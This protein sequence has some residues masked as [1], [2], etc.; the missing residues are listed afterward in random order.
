MLADLRYAIRTLIKSPGYA[1]VAV[2]TLA[3]GIGGIVAMFSAFYGV[4]LAPLPYPQASDIVVPVSTN[5]ARGISDGSVPYADYEDWGRERDVF[6]A[7]ALWL[8]VSVDVSAGS[9]PERLD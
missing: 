3:I 2:A 9:K 4:L 6:A 7:V 8:P 5:A 1:A